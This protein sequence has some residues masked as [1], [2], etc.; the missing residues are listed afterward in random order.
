M[1]AYISSEEGAEIAVILWSLDCS[2]WEIVKHSGSHNYSLNKR[3]SNIL[4]AYI[5]KPNK[6]TS[7][8]PDIL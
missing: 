2:L 6:Y 1:K 7:N 3:V 5:T 4:S 8:N